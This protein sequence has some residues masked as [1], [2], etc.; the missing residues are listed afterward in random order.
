MV[1]LDKGVRDIFLEHAEVKCRMQLKT[2]VLK[3]NNTSGIKI[4]RLRVEEM[5][6]ARPD[7]LWA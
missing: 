3:E 5:S 6:S 7:S 1:I 4:L 2:H